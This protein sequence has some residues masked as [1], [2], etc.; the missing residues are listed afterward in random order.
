MDDFGSGIAVSD[1]DRRPGGQEVRKQERKFL[2]GPD[3]RGSGR[4]ARFKSPL[5]Q[6]YLNPRIYDKNRTEN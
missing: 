6:N 5:W 4:V 3:N 1:G 2:T